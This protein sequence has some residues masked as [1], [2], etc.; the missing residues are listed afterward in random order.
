VVNVPL[1]APEP[2]L[3]DSKTGELIFIWSGCTRFKKVK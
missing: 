2:L 3:I 1:A